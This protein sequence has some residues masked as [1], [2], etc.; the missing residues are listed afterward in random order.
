MNNLQITQALKYELKLASLSDVYK[1]I[2]T[3][4]LATILF[5]LDLFH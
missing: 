5:D 4:E 2:S 3:K 1:T